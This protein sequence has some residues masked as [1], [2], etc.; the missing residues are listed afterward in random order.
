LS[1]S[2]PI[3]P[4]SDQPTEAL[5]AAYTAGRLSEPFAALVAAHLQMREAHWDP[6]A[7]TAG[8]RRPGAEDPMTALMPLALRSYVSRHIGA[9]EWHTLL[10][11]IKQCLIARSVRGGDTRFLRCRPGAAIPSHTH[12]GLEAVLVLQGGFHDVTGHY[13]VGDIAV[14]DSTIDHRPVADRGGECIIFVVL[15]APVRL[16]GWLGR[17]LQRMFGA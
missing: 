8:P 3:H 14:A 6:A 2:G 5:L 13:A 15:E 1:D 9:F 4:R 7:P 12:E 16:T 17:V 10:P 11:G